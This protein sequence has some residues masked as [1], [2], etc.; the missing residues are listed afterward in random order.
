MVLE[1]KIKFWHTLNLGYKNNSQTFE[2][3]AKNRVTPK[4]LRV[5]YGNSENCFTT[6]THTHTQRIDHTYRFS[7][8]YSMAQLRMAKHLR[9]NA[10]PDCRLPQLKQEN[11]R[12]SG[13][14]RKL[15]NTQ[16]FSPE[17]RKI[18]ETI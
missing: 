18:E 11:I 4:N 5:K 10:D 14:S 3:T 9:I 16:K 2:L 17:K 12:T 13:K 7:A 15:R 8:D 1:Y 6:H